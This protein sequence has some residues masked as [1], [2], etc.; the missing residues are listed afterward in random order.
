MSCAKSLASLDGTPQKGS[1]PA[2]RLQLRPLAAQ[3]FLLLLARQLR[4]HRRDGL[5]PTRE[6]LSGIE[7]G[8]RLL[9]KDTLSITITSSP[10]RIAASAA[11]SPERPPPAISSWQVRFSA[12]PDGG[13]KGRTSSS[14]AKG[15]T[16]FETHRLVMHGGGS[17]VQ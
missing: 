16:K 3:A 13:E 1:H 6:E 15:P 8:G 12:V 5:D 14:Y 7:S 11:L 2:L 9:A 17:P 10:C 4:Y